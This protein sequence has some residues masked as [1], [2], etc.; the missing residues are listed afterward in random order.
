MF[1]LYC[2]FILIFVAQSCIFMNYFIWNKSK[3]NVIII[4]PF[5]NI[6][7]YFVTIVQLLMLFRGFA[8]I[9]ILFF[10]WIL[11][12]QLIF[13]ENKIKIWLW[14]VGSFNT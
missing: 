11:Q 12:F 3:V 8:W 4:L 13:N 9:I 14:N 7:V 5:I 2:N 6:I 1:F 10:N